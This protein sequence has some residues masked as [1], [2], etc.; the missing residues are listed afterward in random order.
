MTKVIQFEETGVELGLL[1]E[2]VKGML[3][4]EKFKIVKDD[5]TENAYHLRAVKTQV[6][7]IIIGA[8]RDMSW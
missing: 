4:R 1:Y 5:A 8:A 2:R 6:T 3:V 7:R